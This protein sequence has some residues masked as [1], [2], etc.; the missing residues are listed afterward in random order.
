M[1]ISVSKLWYLYVGVISMLV[2]DI[3]VA[4]NSLVCHVVSHV[5]AT[6][7]DD[8]GIIDRFM[9]RVYGLSE[10]LLKYVALYTQ[11]ALV[12]VSDC[13]VC[14]RL[15]RDRINNCTNLFRPEPNRTRRR[16]FAF[17][18]LLFGNL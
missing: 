9:L 11:F 18:S 7:S 17:V 14:P 5:L 8:P 10:Y 12:L 16:I 6:V 1:V 2:C 3:C 4:V 13:M 15:F